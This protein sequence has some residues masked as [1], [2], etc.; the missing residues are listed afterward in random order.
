M[1]SY[2][3]VTSD[4]P[5]DRHHYILHYTNGR[6]VKYED[7]DVARKAWMDYDKKYV[8]YIEVIDVPQKKSKPK[9]GGFA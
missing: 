7:Y 9:T 1:N 6:K 2:F 4:Q 3:T 8:D 5:Y